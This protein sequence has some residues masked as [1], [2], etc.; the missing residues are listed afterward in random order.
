MTRAKRKIG[1][2]VLDTRTRP[3]SETLLRKWMEETG[4]GTYTLGKELGIHPETVKFWADNQQLPTLVDAFRIEK[5]TA[6]AVPV[7]SWLG[8]Q[9]G[10]VTWN[11]R[12]SNAKK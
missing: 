3:K 4:H 7:A 10:K 6:G 12:M 5:L 9:L 2:Y 8:T 1:V 11:E